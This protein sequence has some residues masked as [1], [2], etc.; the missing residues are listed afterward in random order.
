MREEC[1]IINDT[2]FVYQ[3]GKRKVFERLREVHKMK[4]VFV[5]VL[6]C[7]VLAGMISCGKQD[8]A[9]EETAQAAVSDIFRI[10]PSKFVFTSGAGG[11]GT[12]MTLNEDGTFKGLYHDS[13]MGDTGTGYSNGTVYICDFSGKFTVPEKI[14]EYIYSMNLESLDVEGTPGTVYYENDVRYIVSDPYGFDDAD[15]FL[16]YLPGCPLEETSEEFLSW[17]FINTQIR[18]TIPAGV[19]GIYNVGGMEGFMGEDDDSL[20]RKTYTYSYHSCRSEL[21]PSYDSKSHLNFWPESGAAAL[22]LEFDWSNDSQT[23]FTASD[24]RGTGAY[25]ISLD[26]NEDFRS[27]KVTLKSVSGFSLEPWGGSEDGT[28]S[29]EYQVK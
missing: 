3:R 11:W 1:G 7:V 27:V 18:N 25:H 5:I 19:Y 22:V 12:E 15:E 26:F 4:R 8:K 28:L 17:S 24:D 14:N 6:L 21:Q 16:I 9:A 2:K 10:L 20:W 23:E 29:V 13:D